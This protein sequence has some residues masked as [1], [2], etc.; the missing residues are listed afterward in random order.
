MS[1]RRGK[2]RIG[3]LPSRLRPADANS[4]PSIT[5][6]GCGIKGADDI[7]PAKLASK[8]SH[9]A[10]TVQSRQL[11]LASTSRYRKALLERLGLAFDIASPGVDET[12]LPNESPADTALRLAALKARAMQRA[13]QRCAHHRFGPGGGDGKRALRQ[14]GQPRGGAAPAQGPERQGRRFPHRGEPARRTQRH[15]RVAP[16]AL[17]RVLSTRWTS[18]ASSRTCAASSPTTARRAPR[19]K[20]WASRSSRASRPTIRARS[21]GCRSSR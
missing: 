13:I 11:V 20:A 2:S 8:Q 6:C 16:R 10:M 12:V 17:P 15:R 5:G 1:R 9:G 19:P 4:K 21:S 18:G 3:Q 7:I 14:A